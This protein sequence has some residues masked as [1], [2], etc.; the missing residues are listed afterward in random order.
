[1]RTWVVVANRTEVK[2]FEY[3]NKKDSEVQFLMKFE[4]PRG[5]LRPQQINADKPGIFSNLVSHGTR[6]VKPQSPTERIAQEFAKKVSVFLEEALQKR[7]FDDLVLI[8]DPHFMGRVRS[9]LSK[10][11]RRCITKEII[12]D[13]G[14]VTT[15]EIKN[16]VWPP[17]SLIQ[18]K[19]V[20]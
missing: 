20:L 14:A 5:R 19:E 16:R 1:M 10:E 4:N 8:A 2:V 6:L 7:R 18:A 9:S 3:E 13:L 17:E 12:K 15:E 11:L